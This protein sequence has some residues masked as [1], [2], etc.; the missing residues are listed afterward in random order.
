MLMLIRVISKL[1]KT[2]TSSKYLIEYL[3]KDKRPLT[4]MSKMS[5]YVKLFKVEDKNNELM[6]FHIDDEKLLEN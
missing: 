6:S 5:G 1:A 4:L 2:K 3:D